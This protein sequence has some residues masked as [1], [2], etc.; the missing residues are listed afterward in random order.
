MIQIKKG[1][2]YNFYSMVN[3]VVDELD[4]NDVR[5]HGEKGSLFKFQ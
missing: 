5:R 1:K 4:F 3:K 2:K